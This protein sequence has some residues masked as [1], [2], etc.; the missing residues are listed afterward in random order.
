MQKRN[1]ELLNEALAFHRQ[2]RFDEAESRYKKLT[3]REPSSAAGF[4]GLGA[5]RLYQDRPAEGRD[6]LA[7]AVTLDPGS[8]AIAC[9][10]GAALTQLK[11]FDGA[12]AELRRALALDPGLAEAHNNL[13]ILLLRA[14]RPAEA[15]E[16]SRQAVRLQPGSA[17]M[18]I[19]LG[20]A[21]R[22]SGRPA[23]A[24]AAFETAVR[25]APELAEA[26]FAVATL[27]LAQGDFA[28]G[29]AGFEWRLRLPGFRFAI[30][31]LGKPGWQGEELDGRTIL[32]HAE[33]GLGDTLQFLRY[34]PLVAAR[35]ARVILLVQPALR[36]LLTGLAAVEQVVGFGDTLP[37][38]DLH[39]PLMRLPRRF[40][41]RPDSIPPIGAELSAPAE[42]EALWRSRLGPADGR[43]RIGLVW[44]GNPAHA[45]D[46]N[47]SA[48]LAALAPLLAR[49]DVHWVSLQR[50]VPEGDAAVLAAHPATMQTGA[51]L[52][53][54][55]VTAGLIA[56]LDLVVSVDTA[57]AHLAGVMGRPVWLLLPFAPEWRWLGT[58]GDSP[59]YP[60]A[61]LF[62]QPK[63]GDW[64]GLVR[65]VE[66]ALASGF[67]QSG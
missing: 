2:G 8:A 45:N 9:A 31:D 38:Y 64:A 58:R 16:S 60:T 14:L 13:S 59:W 47:R 28:A 49:S 30:P 53:D 34:V 25:L 36:R 42:D 65:E 43:T 33:Q 50:D 62:R 23:E 26:H 27:Q 7:R 56:G 51:A 61:R 67:T 44:A 32:L 37:D 40:G 55:A 52:T 5:L 1:A 54:L 41:T 35:G 11:E 6:Y 39:C 46:Y 63:P 48:P 22:D 29:W 66:T 21:L 3:W 57:A 19:N 17:D 24:L 10:L 15:V 18:A 20:K 12:E 4:H